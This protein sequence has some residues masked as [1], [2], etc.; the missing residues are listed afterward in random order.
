MD[1]IALTT[2]IISQHGVREG[3]CPCALILMSRPVGLTLDMDMRGRMAMGV[4][5]CD[6]QPNLN[7]NHRSA[8]V[9]T[10]IKHV[11]TGIPNMS[12]CFIKMIQPA[13]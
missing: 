7:I 3:V 10:T 9:A 2:L 12:C 4:C 5:V 11:F 6:A 8:R 1:T 13:T